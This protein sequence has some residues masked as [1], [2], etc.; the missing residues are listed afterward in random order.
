M[1]VIFVT[2]LKTDYVLGKL[3]LC[4][5]S[6]DVFPPAQVIWL[7]SIFSFFLPSS[8]KASSFS[9]YARSHFLAFCL[10]FNSFK[11]HFQKQ[12]ASQKCIINAMLRQQSW[13]TKHKDLNRA[14]MLKIFKLQISPLKTCTA[15]KEHYFNELAKKDPLQL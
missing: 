13:S 10:F 2:S 11:L 3:H 5:N 4:T 8:R 1:Q 15:K 12:K 7:F 6:F 14:L 9:C